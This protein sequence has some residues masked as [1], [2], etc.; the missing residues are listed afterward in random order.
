MIEIEH[1]IND[2]KN[3]Y[4]E[5]GS[6]I[7]LIGNKIDC[8]LRR[9]ISK[10]EAKNFA[11]KYN[12]HYYECCCINGLKV[13]EI[14]KEMLVLAYNKFYQKYPNGIKNRK[15]FKL[16]KNLKKVNKLT[17]YIKY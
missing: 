3:K 1:Y 14:L 2:I 13:L 6:E 17:K 8:I 16:I 15:Y 10:R 7:I 11:E 12:I 5:E 4:G 9:V